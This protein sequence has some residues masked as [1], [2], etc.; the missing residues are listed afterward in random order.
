MLSARIPNIVRKEVYR[1]DG[2]RCALCDDTR[3][4]Q[5]HHVMKRSQGGTNDPMNLITLCWRCHATVHGTVMPE[6]PDYMNPVEIHH[7]CIE[8]LAD[9]YAPGWYPWD[10]DQQSC[11][12]SGG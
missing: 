12:G 4:L 5:I 2:F 10:Y 1:R 11:H 3:G 7:A 9:Y 8:Y 6:Y